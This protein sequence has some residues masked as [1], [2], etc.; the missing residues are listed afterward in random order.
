MKDCLSVEMRL[1]E[2]LPHLP[3]YFRDEPIFCSR[4]DLNNLLE[5]NDEMFLEIMEERFLSFDFLFG[6]L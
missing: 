3:G 1:D 6:V 4:F 2:N 5:S